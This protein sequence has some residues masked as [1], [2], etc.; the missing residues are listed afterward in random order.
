[1]GREEKL[2]YFRKSLEL[3]RKYRID[4]DVNITEFEKFKDELF[5][6]L[7]HNRADRLKN[8]VYYEVND[9]NVPF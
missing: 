9:D 2:E 5:E 8:L 6:Q 4:P 7:K 1:M 3:L